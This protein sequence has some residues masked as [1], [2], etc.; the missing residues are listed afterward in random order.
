[1]RQSEGDGSGEMDMDSKFQQLLVSVLLQPLNPVVGATRRPVSHGYRSL[2]GDTLLVVV[3]VVIN[4][5]NPLGWL[6]GLI[7]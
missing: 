1:M 6:V 7:F 2:N 3:V 4:T 5:V